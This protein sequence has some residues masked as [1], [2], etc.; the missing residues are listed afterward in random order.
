MVLHTMR[1]TKKFLSSVLLKDTT[2]MTGTR[3]LTW[4]P[5]LESCA[6]RELGQEMERELRIVKIPENVLQALFSNLPDVTVQAVYRPC[7]SPEIQYCRFDSL[8]LIIALLFFSRKFVDSRR[9]RET[10]RN[11]I[12]EK[13]LMNGISEGRSNMAWRGRAIFLWLRGTTMRKIKTNYWNFA[14]QQKH[15]NCSGCHGLFWG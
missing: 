5:E 6:I 14:P 3:T 1:R 13:I 15:S 2:A 9:L 4:T 11:W 8:P 10:K 7:E 12:Q